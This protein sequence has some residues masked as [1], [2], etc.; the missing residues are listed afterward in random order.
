MDNRIAE[1]FI[2]I[3]EPNWTEF[4]KIAKLNRIMYDAKIS[5][6]FKGY[7]QIEFYSKNDY[8]KIKT[9]LNKR[10]I[11]Y[12]D[13]FTEALRSYIQKLVREFISK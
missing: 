8:T 11:P 4:E 5:P 3:D 10:N 7:T 2:H 12:K 13:R 1:N 9:L 6:L